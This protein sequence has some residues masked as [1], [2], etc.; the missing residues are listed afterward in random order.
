M[1]RLQRTLA[2]VGLD[3]DGLETTRRKQR[4]RA[5][6][7]RVLVQQELC[8]R[9]DDTELRDWIH[10]L[11]MHS[12]V[13]RADEMDRAGVL[14]VTHWVRTINPCEAGMFAFFDPADNTFYSVAYVAHG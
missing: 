13:R 6:N 10:S 7:A 12:K 3:N 9:M 4:L 1:N 2:L 5:A 14:D 11:P 8:R